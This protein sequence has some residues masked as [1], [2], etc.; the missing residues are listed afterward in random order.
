MSTKPNPGSKEAREQGCLC[1]VIDNERG[2]GYLGNGEQ[3]GFVINENCPLH[4]P[5][6][7]E[8]T[9]IFLE[10]FKNAM[11]RFK[12]NQEDVGNILGISRSSV[13][14]I[15]QGKQSNLATKLTKEIRLYTRYG[16]IPQ[17][18]LITQ[19]DLDQLGETMTKPTYSKEAIEFTK[20]Y[21]IRN[22]ER[23]PVGCLVA[24]LVPVGENPDSPYMVA[25][26]LAMCNTKHDAFVKKTGK[27][28]AIARAKEHWKEYTF[29]N[30][31]TS[32]Y[33]DVGIEV[34]NFIRECVRYYKNK[35]II[36]PKIL[37]AYDKY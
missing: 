4:A 15:L 3:F 23:E 16:K 12:H 2:R 22:N 18:E 14:R 35:S 1:P 19:K 20:V 31:Q 25:I 32:D 21:Y 28:L 8:K 29:V 17:E 26:G 36:L 24:T 5:T 6:T 11:K 30:Y 9:N 27:E 7:E 10:Q 37:L 13:S 33:Q 34:F